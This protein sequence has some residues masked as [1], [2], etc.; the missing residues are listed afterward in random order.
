MCHTRL[1]FSR[2]DAFQCVTHAVRRKWQHRKSGETRAH[3]LDWADDRCTPKLIADLKAVLG[4]L[5]VFTPLVLFWALYEQQV[6]LPLPIRA[7]R[8][9]TARTIWSGNCRGLG[10]ADTRTYI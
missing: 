9:E 3:W 1:Q 10:Y 8:R 6:K 2:S 5:L 7:F 4:V